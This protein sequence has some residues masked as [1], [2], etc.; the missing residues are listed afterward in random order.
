[1]INIAGG[2]YV[3]KPY[4]IQAFTRSDITRKHSKSGPAP[5]MDLEGSINQPLDTTRDFLCRVMVD[6]EYRSYLAN[7]SRLLGADLYLERSSCR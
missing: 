5:K 2:A 3:K 4:D 6:R 7:L 1:M